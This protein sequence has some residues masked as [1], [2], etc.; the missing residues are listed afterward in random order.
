MDEGGTT[1]TGRQNLIRKTSAGSWGWATGDFTTAN[2]YQDWNMYTVVRDGTNYNTYLNAESKGSIAHGTT[3]LQ[4]TIAI[5]SR[6]NGAGYHI[7]AYVKRVSFYDRDLST[8]EL[9]SLYGQMTLKNNGDMIT[10]FLSEINPNVWPDPDLSTLSY[11][12]SSGTA[13]KETTI[14]GG[15]Y[16]QAICSGVGSV[17]KGYDILDGPRYG[18]TYKEGL[19]TGYTYIVSG[20]FWVSASNT[21]SGTVIRIENGLSMV[22]GP[23][24]SSIASEEWVYCTASFVADDNVRVLIYPNFS[25]GGNG[26]AR[27]KNI[28]VQKSVG[29]PVQLTENRELYTR[30]IDEGNNFNI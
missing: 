9:T 26:T 6:E 2:N 18:L 25:G 28:S 3:T 21:L 7:P 8:D 11:Q 19:E 30:D 20:Y 17:Y 27:W 10:D 16:H 22:Q 12:Y 1:V 5:G 13:T 15:T 23:S 24:W 4:S 14:S 29:K